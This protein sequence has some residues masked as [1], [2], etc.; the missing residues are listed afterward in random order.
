MR[1][2]PAAG[3]AAT[4]QSGGRPDVARSC[5]LTRRRCEEFAQ[6]PYRAE[7]VH[8]NR[9][10]TDAERGADLAVLCSAM[11]QSVNTRCLS[12]SCS[13]AAAIS[14]ARSLDMSRASGPG[15]GAT[16]PGRRV[17]GAAAGITHPQAARARLADVETGVHEDA[18][19]PYFEREVL[20]VGRDMGEHF[21]NAS[22]TASSAS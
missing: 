7:Q 20:P 11:W 1:R 3:G 21:T 13:I 18:G 15:C 9:R 22:C 16:D 17:A 6:A 2:S 19:E 8:A 4:D 10:F 12:G 14:R 5:N